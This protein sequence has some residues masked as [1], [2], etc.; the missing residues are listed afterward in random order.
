[1][2]LLVVVTCLLDV[3]MEDVERHLED[4]A[5]SWVWQNGFRNVACVPT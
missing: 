3:F 5:S 4:S 2:K 1:M